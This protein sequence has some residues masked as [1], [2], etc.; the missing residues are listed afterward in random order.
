M[1]TEYCIVLYFGLDRFT[2]L[3][4]RLLVGGLG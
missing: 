4:V 1:D 2:V 3:A